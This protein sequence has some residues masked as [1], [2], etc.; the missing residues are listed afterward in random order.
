MLFL[1]FVLSVGVS[2]S[3][4]GTSVHPDEDNIS[5]YARMVCIHVIGAYV[6]MCVYVGCTY[7]CTLACLCISVLMY[8]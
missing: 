3:V 1:L 5:V 2:M 4:C 7:V 6:R 8:A